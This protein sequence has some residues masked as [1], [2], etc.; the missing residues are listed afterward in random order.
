MPFAIGAMPTNRLGAGPTRGFFDA[1]SRVYDLPLVQL[2]TYRPV[3]DAVLLTL[4]AEPCARVLAI[5][6]GT[7]RLAERLID[8]PGVC[9]VVG[10]DFLIGMLAHA[11]ERLRAASAGS[12]R[13]ALVRGDA[14][15]L[16]LACDS[17]ASHSG[18][19]RRAF[20]ARRASRRA[21]G[22]SGNAASSASR[23]F[24]CRRC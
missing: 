3:Y 7:G 6:C 10:C 16:R 9:S 1:W 5:D 21:F 8:A 2:A 19:R 14:T 18:G 4:A 22:S 23:A 20:S 13:V 12:I 11:A 24:C 15:R 17:S